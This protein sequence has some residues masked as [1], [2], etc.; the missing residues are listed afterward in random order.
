MSYSK[1]VFY[2]RD[3]LHFFKSRG[4]STLRTAGS[5]HSTPADILAIKKGC[6]IAI[7][8]K[9]HKKK[10]K[11]KKEKVAE[12]KEWCEQAGALGF[13]AWRAPLQEWWF[14]PMEHL[15]NEKY[16]DEHWIETNPLLKMLEN[17]FRPFLTSNPLRICSSE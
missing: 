15:E 13:L 10:P 3:L 11:L 17:H 4:F 16:H 9:A 5:G 8:C 7:E 12:L 2:E 6:I 14:L 1:G